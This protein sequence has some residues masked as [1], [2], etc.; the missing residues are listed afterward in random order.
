M[1]FKIEYQDPE[2]DEI[3][4]E[5]QEFTST[6]DPDIS[7]EMWAED[8]AYSRADKGFHTVKEVK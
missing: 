1:K 6:M 7:A 8:Y 5:I 4:T 2:T 3:V